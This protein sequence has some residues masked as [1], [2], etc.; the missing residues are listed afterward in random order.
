MT[1]NEAIDEVQRVGTIRAENGKL[2]VRFPEC[3]REAL[4]AAIDTLR[5]DRAEALAQLSQLNPA[6][7]EPLEMVLQG[8]AIELWST[9]VGRLFLVADDEDARRLMDGFGAQRGEVYTAAEARRIVTV[10]DPPVVAEIHAWKRQF[11]GVVREVEGDL[12]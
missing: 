3:E 2:K 5:S 12:K 10:D 4:E 6:N 7:P 9:E 8:L 1:V 11:D